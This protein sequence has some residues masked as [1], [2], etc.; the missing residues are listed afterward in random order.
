MKSLP[1]LCFGARFNLFNQALLVVEPLG[2]LRICRKFLAAAALSD[3][4]G[5]WHLFLQCSKQ[6]SDHRVSLFTCFQVPLLSQQ[7]CLV[8]MQ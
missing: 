7:P 1:R 6:T 4:R 5:L 2:R 8:G 3:A